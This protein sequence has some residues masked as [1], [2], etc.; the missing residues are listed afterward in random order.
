MSANVKEVIE[1][2]I[3]EVA[4]TH[5]IKLPALKGKHEVVDD[6]GFTS[7]MVAAIIANLEEELDIDPFEDEDVMITDIRTID[8]LVEVYQNCL[9][10]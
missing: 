7:L 10:G 9:N 6:L 4:E 8:D 3:K 2:V 1:S 5:D